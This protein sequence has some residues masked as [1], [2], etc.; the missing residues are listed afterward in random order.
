M[1]STRK[2]TPA[3]GQSTQQPSSHLSHTTPISQPDFSVGLV[4][5][6][7]EMAGNENENGL[8]LMRTPTLADFGISV[9]SLDFLENKP[10]LTKPTP[11]WTDGP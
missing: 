8:N 1:A 7:A 3:I 4:D 11:V 6:T 5:S 2:Y 10:E 9:Q